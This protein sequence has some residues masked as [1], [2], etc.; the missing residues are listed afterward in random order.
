VA[1]AAATRQADVAAERSL[2]AAVQA[3]PGSLE[4][5][6]SA[7]GE[8]SAFLTR[9]G[10]IGN[11][12]IATEFGFWRARTQLDE[13]NGYAEELRKLLQQPEFLEGIRE[14]SPELGQAFEAT[15]AQVQT[16]VNEVPFGRR[17]H[18]LHRSLIPCYQQL[19]IL[20]NLLRCIIVRIRRQRRGENAQAGSLLDPESRRQLRASMRETVPCWDKE[21]WD[22]YDTV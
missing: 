14:R 20:E 18:L 16:M 3:Q 1:Q 9:L 21:T 12:S 7:L 4:N 22:L 11:G 15:H 17:V 5:V 13:L 2:M 19:Y 8:L 10:S 6:S